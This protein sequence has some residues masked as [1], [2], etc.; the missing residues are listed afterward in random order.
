MR[1]L[2]VNGI[3]I[4]RINLFESDR[5]ITVVS[6]SEGKIQ[7]KAKNIRKI[8]SR[9]I[10]HMELLNLASFSVYK[11]SIN[12][13]PLAIEV[14]SAKTYSNIKSNL[15]KSNLSYHICE[16]VDSLLPMGNDNKNIFYLLEEVL[17][18]LEKAV[19]DFYSLIHDFETKLLFDLGFSS[20][21]LNLKGARASLFIE[22]IIEKK[23]KA[24]E[25]I[26]KINYNNF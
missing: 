18:N 26:K 19:D 5:I 4:K 16:I 11:S 15:I 12:S 13:M 14:D 9:R 8:T 25:I 23:L 2:K 20:S 6:P 7:F 10:S 22:N 21:S 24:R 1:N 3:I 17:D